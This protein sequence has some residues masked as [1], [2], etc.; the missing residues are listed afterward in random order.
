VTRPSGKA[1]PGDVLAQVEADLRALW[2]TPPR[3][4]ETPTA[5]ACTMNLVVV[6]A[7]PEYTEHW[8]PIIDDVIQA[9]PS[10]AIVVGLDPDAEDGLEAETSAV[11]APA[12]GGGPMVCSERVT[13]LA[14]GALCARLS[15]CVGALCSPDVPTT[16]VW[17]GRVHTDDRAFA[18]L[19]REANRIVLDATQ[20][21]LASLAHVVAWARA[22]A[23]RDR[24]GVADLAW[25][26]L[27]PW[28]EMC[29][30]LFDDPRLRPLANHVSRVS[31]TQASKVGAPLGVE[32]ALV[33]G[34]LATRLGWKAGSIA[35]K[36]RLVRPD[37]VIVRSQL[38]ADPSTKASPGSL[39][40]VMV[41]ASLG[42]MARRGSVGRE[43][44]DPDAATW[45]LEVAT[46]GELQRIEQHVRLRSTD[47]AGLLERTLHRPVHDEALAEAAAW[48]DELRG[49]ELACA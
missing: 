37:D 48:A 26:R 18:P 21:S 29:A 44:S 19:A 14:R 1:R 30:R 4:G 38:R 17:L 22:R 7:N 24:P 5:R 32:G 35:G 6:G 13:L 11:C 3:P 10:R 8:V 46:R 28:Q 23:P 36:L 43:T 45:S 49:E 27:A 15:S 16:I 25:T 40:A 42:D 34:W 41:E 20:G 12:I 47:P 39:V 9:V 2:A 31:I 33:L